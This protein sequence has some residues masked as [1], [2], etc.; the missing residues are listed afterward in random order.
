M[1]RIVA[2]LLVTCFSLVGSD[3]SSAQGLSPT[4]SV[5]FQMANRERFVLAPNQ[6][7][8]I[9]VECP[10]PITIHSEPF[11]NWGVSSN[12]GTKENGA[13]FQGWNC[14]TNFCQWNSC[15]GAHP[16]PDC[17]FYNFAGCTQQK[18]TQGLNVYG[19]GIYTSEVECPQFS[20]GGLH[21]GCEIL[22]GFVLTVN[23]NF[24]TLYELDPVCCDDLVQSMVFPPTSVTLSCGVF[25]CTA[26]P[27]PWVSPTSYND[28]VWPPLVDTEIR[29]QLDYAG[30]DDSACSGCPPP[31][32]ICE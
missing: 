8:D 30:L 15:T 21:G 31:P 5:V 29:L 14:G 24:M 12:V 19:H 6:G 26:T 25:S 20:G 9:N 16:P 3:W 13:Q 23:D 4:C 22:D 10:H 1:K 32:M 17:E 28:P 7:V 18:S 11:G 2:Y 27:S